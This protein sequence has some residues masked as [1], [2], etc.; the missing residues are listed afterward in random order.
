V[1]L[2]EGSDVEECPRR[3]VEMG[4][5]IVGVGMGGE[6]WSEGGGESGM[7]GGRGEGRM[8]GRGR[9]GRWR[10]CEGDVGGG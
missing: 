10:G 4:E 7:V 1:F 2:R 8:G 3:G 6:R 5:K 9:G